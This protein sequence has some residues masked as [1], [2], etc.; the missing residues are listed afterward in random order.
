MPLCDTQSGAAWKAVRRFRDVPSVRGEPGPGPRSIRP[1]FCG[2]GACVPTSG[3]RGG[4]VSVGGPGAG[5]LEKNPSLQA[6]RLQAEADHAGAA[7]AG[8]WQPPRVGVEFFQT[9]VSSFPNPIRGQMETDYFVEQSIPFPGK[10]GA[11]AEAERWRAR[12]GDG[13]A[14][15]VEDGIVRDVKTAYYNL[16]LIDARGR[17]NAESQVL[18][19][20]LIE[21]A[22]KQYEVGLGR[23]ADILRAQAELSAL[24]RTPSPWKRPAWPLRET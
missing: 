20:R 18:V 6:A 24:Q 3:R 12:A 5:S 16:C 14:G 23:Q 19:L 4:T 11:R 2:H 17:I 7:G 13:L 22:R 15:A 9:P 1:A 10:R 8:A 21:T